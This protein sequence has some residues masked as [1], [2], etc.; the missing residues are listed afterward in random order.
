M[1]TIEEIAAKLDGLEARL[2]SLPVQHPPAERLPSDP[3]QK[4]VGSA[5]SGDGEQQPVYTWAQLQQA[6]Q[7]NKIT[8]EVAQQIWADQI[9]D[10]AV[11]TATDTVTT[12]LSDTTSAARVEAEIAKY[13]EAIPQIMDPASE[14]RQRVTREFMRLTAELGYARDNLRT[15]LVALQA[16][17][18]PIDQVVKAVKTRTEGHRDVSG[19]TDP[20]PADDD[21]DQDPG[22][23]PPSSMSAEERRYYEHAIRNKVY[24]NWGAVREE[25]KFANKRLRRKY[26]ARI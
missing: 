7:E 18:G 21:K 26:G 17:F 3:N 23:T 14:Q 12:T 11:K 5:A 25:L 8:E 24:Q 10:R 20:G 9:V 13:R 6:V 2:A 22:N 1:A 19:D 16:A 15:E 4:P